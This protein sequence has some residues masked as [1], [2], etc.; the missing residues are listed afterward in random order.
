[1]ER[2]TVLVVDDEPNI[3]DLIELYLAARATASSRPEPAKAGPRRRRAPAPPRRARRRPARHRRARGVPPAPP[4]VDDPGDLPHRA[5]RRGRPRARTRARRRR[6]RDE[7]VLAARA[8]GA[9]EG[10]AAPHRPGRRRAEVVQVGDAAI[11][12][13]RREVRVRGE[14]RRVHDQGVRAAPVPRRAAGTRAEPPADPRRRVGLRLVRRRRAPSTCTSRRSARSSTARCGS[15]RYAASATASRPI[16][17]RQG[18]SGA[19]HADRVAGVEGRRSKPHEQPSL[20]TRLV[21]AM[22]LLSFAVLGLSYVTTYVLVRRELQENALGN[23]RSRAAELR[24]RCCLAG[25]LVAAG[26]HAAPPICAPGCGSRIS[27]PCS[28][29]PT[30][31][32]RDAGSGAFALPDSLQGSTLD[33]DRLLAG[34]ELSGRRRQHGVS[35]PSRPVRSAGSGSS[36]S[37]PT[38][39]TPRSCRGRRRGCSSPGSSCSGS[40]RRSQCGSPAGSRGRS[41]RSSGPRTNSRSGDLSGRADVPPGTDVDLAALADTLNEMAAQL[42][43]SR[44]SR[45]RVPALDLARPPHAAHLDPRLRRSARR[46]HARR[47]RP[48][49]AQARRDRDRRRGAPPRAS[50]PRPARPVAGSTAASSRSTRS[51][52]TRPRSCATR[53]RRS[54]RRR[55]SSASSCTSPRAP[56]PRPSSTPT[57]SA[58]IVANLVENALKYARRPGS[59]SRPSRTTPNSRIVVTDDGPGIPPAELTVVFDRLYTVAARRAGRVGTGLGLA[60]VQELAVAMGGTAA[61]QSPPAGG[62]QLVVSLPVTRAAARL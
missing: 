42:E 28:S 43:A 6:L 1:M 34:Q 36:S 5:R 11:D 19:G 59:R 33:A 23:L 52:A 20:V 14:R 62:A 4:D 30:A 7:A 9:R 26:R 35:S 17:E 22:V 50:R 58:Q 29:A 56:R 57:G 12:L 60:I 40:R 54:R 46:R 38:R 8:R 31:S 37:P 10:G 44:G 25:R 49:R 51:R 45:A 55:A 16:V 27:A 32:S 24:P 53:P 41:A 48:R 39:S 21:A 13:G 2:G 3:A 15:T 18:R 61:A 47:R